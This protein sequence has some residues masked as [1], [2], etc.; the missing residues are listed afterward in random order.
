M[1]KYSPDKFPGLLENP[2]GYRKSS[3]DYA[4]TISVP[5][6]YVDRLK[7]LMQK[8]GRAFVVYL[9]QVATP[10]QAVALMDAED[11][12]AAA[13]RPATTEPHEAGPAPVSLDLMAQVLG[14]DPRT[15]QLDAEKGLLVRTA[16]GQYDTLASC[17]TLRKAML[18]AAT[19]ASDAY[20]DERTKAM[21]LKRQE[22][23]LNY[24]ERA[25][26]LVSAEAVGRAIEKVAAA[27]KQRLLFL[28]KQLAPQLEGDA[29]ERETL[30]EEW[31]HGF[32]KAMTE[33]DLSAAAAPAP[34]QDKPVE[35][36]AKRKRRKRKK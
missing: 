27:E 34:D 4:V 9:V 14:V 23:E 1:E 36:S 20:N 15:V 24:L 33:I 29:A 10:E 25:G 26:K 3:D 35:V 5:I 12:P 8:A 6:A 22:R 31:V 19:G 16:R 17:A 7:P 2:A 28:P 21:R 18:A 11:S 13:L 30:L 32:L